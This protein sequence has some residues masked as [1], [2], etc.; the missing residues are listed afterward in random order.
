M[1]VFSAGK[2]D[3]QVDSTSQAL[4]WLLTASQEPGLVT[5][6]ERQ[7]EKALNGEIA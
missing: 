5:Y 3:D 7:A 6:Y 2:H 4:H 1:T